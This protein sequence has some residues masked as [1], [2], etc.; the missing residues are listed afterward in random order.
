[1]F[2]AVIGYLYIHGRLPFGRIALAAGMISLSAIFFFLPIGTYHAFPVWLIAGVPS[3]ILIYGLVSVEIPVPRLIVLGGEASYVLYLIHE[4]GLGV[5]M[6]VMRKLVGFN[7]FTVEW[8]GV[9]IVI[10]IIAASILITVTVERR[11]LRLRKSSRA[12]PARS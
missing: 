7:P 10:G 3:A 2:G 11:I 6:V 9:L 5:S 8:L 12:K 4:L 1:M